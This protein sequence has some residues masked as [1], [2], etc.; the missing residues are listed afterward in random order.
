MDLILVS[1][2]LA[3]E[4][5]VEVVGTSFGSDHFLVIGTM[6]VSLKYVKSALNRLNVKNVD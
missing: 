6:D 4:S 1:A 5:T 2:S 3:Q